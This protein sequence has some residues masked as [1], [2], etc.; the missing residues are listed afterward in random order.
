MRTLRPAILMRALR[1]PFVVAVMLPF[2]AGSVLPEGPVRWLRCLLGLLAAVCTHLSAN[3]INDSADSRTGADW[4]DRTYH[5][6]LF[7]GSKLIQ[8]YLLTEG[9]FRRGAFILGATAFMIVLLLSAMMR[10][11]ELI[12]WY[13]MALFLAWAYSEAPFRL[14]YHGFGE[15]IVFLLFGPAAVIAAFF[16]QTGRFPAGSAFLLGMPY[17]LL[18]AAV[19]VANEVPD[20][21]SDA[22]AG[23][24]HLVVRIGRGNGYRLYYLLAAAGLL[25][26][27]L[28]VAADIVKSWALLAF[29]IV[30]PIFLAGEILRD[31]DADKRQHLKSSRLTLAAQAAAGL[32]L[33]GAAAA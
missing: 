24:R 4:Y 15:L 9:F 2:A 18:T 21:I 27:A 23:K 31:A 5:G 17:G 14:A 10:R 7:G 1:L 8:Q 13:A 3:L 33:W 19:L 32:I 30:V 12:V 11:P 20:C 29:V 22:A 6:G 25:S 26:I 28:N 16:L